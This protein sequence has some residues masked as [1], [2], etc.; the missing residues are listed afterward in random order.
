MPDSSPESFAHTYEQEQNTNSENAHTRTR[1]GHIV[2]DLAFGVWICDAQGG[3]E[4]ASDSFLDLL[5]MSMEEASG[6]GW[7]ERLL[8]GNGGS[9][10]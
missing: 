1:A 4:Y 10:K 9:L 2:E 3:L 6:F 8:H 5:N 7:A